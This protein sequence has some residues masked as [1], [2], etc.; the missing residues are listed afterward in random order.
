[1]AWFLSIINKVPEKRIHLP[2]KKF[3]EL[4]ICIIIQLHSEAVESNNEILLIVGGH[5]IKNFEFLNFMK[6]DVNGHVDIG[7]IKLL[8]PFEMRSYVSLLLYFRDVFI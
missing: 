7:K 6:I 8:L 3:V 2:D 1:M 5:N 4:L